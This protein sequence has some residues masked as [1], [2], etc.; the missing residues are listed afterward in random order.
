MLGHVYQDSQ[1][2]DTTGTGSLAERANIDGLQRRIRRL[3]D[4]VDRLTLA[5]MAF[6]E[7][8]RDRLGVPQAEI[9]GKMHEI[10][11]RDGRLD[12]K[13]SRPAPVCP[14]C[15]RVNS[16]HRTACLYCGKPLPVEG[17]LGSSLSN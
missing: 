3:E 7:L 9:E 16:P 4:Q 5:S 12:G 13:L 1:F 8:L 14:T 15:Q 11:L 2:D 6:T 17:I 10:D